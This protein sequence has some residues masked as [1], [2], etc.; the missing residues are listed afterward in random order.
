MANPPPKNFETGA[1]PP[2]DAFL[3]GSDT[4]WLKCSTRVLA[5][6]I[7]RRKVGEPRLASN[8]TIS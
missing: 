3:I 2:P 5:L 1:T 7:H 8:E 6:P 4:P